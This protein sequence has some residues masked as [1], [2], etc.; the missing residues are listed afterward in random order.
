RPVPDCLPC[1]I[2]V[3]N[4]YIEILRRSG[5]S[6]P[7]GHRLLTPNTYAPSQA[8]APVHQRLDSPGRHR[9]A[10]RNGIEVAMVMPGL[11]EM[12]LTSSAWWASGEPGN[13]G[14]TQ[15]CVLHHGEKNGCTM[16]TAG[17]TRA[18]TASTRL[19]AASAAPE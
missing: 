14:G 10:A 9:R 5:P 4:G 11:R 8:A 3:S 13:Q 1:S 18:T 6:A 12:N 2:R 17:R 15:N 19:A 7:V 16:S